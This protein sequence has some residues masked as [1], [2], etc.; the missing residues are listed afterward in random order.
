[1][2][3]SRDPVYIL[4][5][6]MVKVAQVNPITGVPYTP[7]NPHPNS[8]GANATHYWHGRAK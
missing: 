1:M 2:Q 3:I 4:P 5:G 8:I 7:A 6:I